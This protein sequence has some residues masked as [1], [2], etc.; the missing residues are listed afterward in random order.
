MGYVTTYEIIAMIGVTGWL[1]FNA[2]FVAGCAW[3]GTRPRQNID[4]ENT[5]IRC[6]LT[7]VE[8]AARKAGV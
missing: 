1:I 7:S 8:D 6:R 2:G 4:V 5:T 3:K